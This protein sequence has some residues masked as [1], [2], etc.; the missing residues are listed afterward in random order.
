MAQAASA[1]RP[2]RAPPTPGS[3]ARPQTATITVNPVADTPSVTNATTAEDVQT[4]SGLVVTRA[5]QDGAE[6]TH[7]KIT[8]I[9]NGTL[10]QNDGVT[11]INNGDFITF[12]QASAGL[13]FT[14]ATDQNSPGAVFSFGVQAST[15]NTDAGLGGSIQ[16]ATITVTEVNDAPVAVNDVVGNVAEDSGI[17]QIDFATLTGNDSTGPTNENGQTLSVTN[18]LNAVGGTVQ[19]VGGHIEFT[20]DADFNGA[21]SFD[22]EVT[23]NGT[24]NGGAD[25]KSGTGHVTF[26]V[27]AV[28]DTV[29]DTLATAEDTA[30]TANVITGTNG[31]SADNFEDSGRTLTGVTQGANGTVGFLADGSVTY[32]PE[33]RLQRHRQ[34]HLHGDVGRGDRD[35]QCHRQ[36]RRRRRHR[37]RHGDH[38]RGHRRS[39][40]LVH[41]RPTVARH[42]GHFEHDRRANGTVDH[43]QQRHR[44][45]PRRRLRHLHAER[46]LLRHRQLHLHGDVGRRDRDGQRHG[47]R[48]RQPDDA[49]HSSPST[50]RRP[51]PRTAGASCSTTT[52]R[53]PTSTRPG[54]VRRRDAD[55]GTPGRRQPRRLFDAHGP[56]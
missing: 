41:R 26:D 55:A 35:R 18:V 20:P 21:A 46:R 29:N 39:T 6:V 56:R 27:T 52:R 32:T 4:T 7:F 11:Q 9:T 8:G 48:H 30:I 44:W 49:P 19:I 31:A 25:P 3:A 42:A 5:A 2:R 14:P 17:Y 38:R 23:D 22:Y 54:A 47:H 40:S 53:S 24:T 33:R 15:S 28:G 45:R 13:K 51:T 16:T 43:Q 1:S 10:F 34:L 12:A 37:R 50:T 36:R